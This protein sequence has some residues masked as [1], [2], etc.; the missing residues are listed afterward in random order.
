MSCNC[1]CTCQG[2]SVLQ[3]YFCHANV[4]AS[5]VNVPVSV[6]YMHTRIF[7]VFDSCGMQTMASIWPVYDCYKSVV[8]G[9]LHNVAQ[10]RK[11]MATALLGHHCF[12]SGSSC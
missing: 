11:M 3:E 1:G 7:Q 9:L 8:E 5:H 10:V 12:G 2:V 4:Y 6:S